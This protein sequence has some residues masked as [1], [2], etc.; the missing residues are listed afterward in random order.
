MRQF[1][2]IFGIIGIITFSCEQEESKDINE[3]CS[4]KHFYYANGEKHFID[5]LMQ[6]DYLLIGFKKEYSKKEIN[7]FLDKQTEFN[8]ANLYEKYDISDYDYSLIVREFKSSKT[9]MQIKEIIVELQSEDIVAFASY[10]YKGEFC[11]GW[12][13]T[14][15]KSYINQIIVSLADTSD[16]DKLYSL[17]EHTDTWIIKEKEFYTILGVEVDAER[18]ALEMAQYFYETGIF[19]YTNPHFIYF[20]LDQKKLLIQPDLQREPKNMLPASYSLNP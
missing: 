14:D 10:T 12:E 8:N 9:C 11:I 1:I 19:D 18:N 20:G 2:Y 3:T 16:T 6:H 4:E 15:I 17:V 5:T 7:D 13:C